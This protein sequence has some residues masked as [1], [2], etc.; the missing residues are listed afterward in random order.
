MTI[1]IINIGALVDDL[2]DPERIFLYLI[3]NIYI[4]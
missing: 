4:G 1:I 2:L 3:L